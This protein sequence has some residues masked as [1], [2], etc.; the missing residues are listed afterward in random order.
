MDAHSISIAVVDDHWAIRSGLKVVLKKMDYVESVQSFAT[1]AE[2]Y[3]EMK[4]NPFD[5]IILDVELKGENGLDICKEV[6]NQYKN[7]KVLMSTM[8]DNPGYVIRA[9]ENKAD[10]YILKDTT[11]KEMKEAI[12]KIVFQNKTYYPAYAA[13]LIFDKQEADRKIKADAELTE[14]EIEVM[15]LIC[16]GKTDKEIGKLKNRSEATISTHRQ[17]ILKKIK[18]HKTADIIIYAIQNGIYIP[19][20]IN[21][22]IFSRFFKIT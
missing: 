14:S 17:N 5:L 9:Y 6:K 15:K 7:T 8:F 2:F 13:K 11:P 20:K 21:K 3:P 22:R 18:G 12:D 4:L 1:S 10:G 16:E 19:L